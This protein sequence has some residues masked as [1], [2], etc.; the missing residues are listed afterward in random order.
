[1]NFTYFRR[2]HIRYRRMENSSDSLNS[3]IVI[4]RKRPTK[5]HECKIHIQ[6]DSK[7]NVSIFEGDSVSNCEKIVYVNMCLILNGC[8]DRYV[9]IS[10][11]NTIR[12][13]F[14]G[15]CGERSLQKKNGYTRRTARLHFV[16]YWRHKLTWKW[17]QTNKTRYSHTSCEV[18][19][20]WRRNFRTFTV[21]CKFVTCV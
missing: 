5:L 7:G 8:R 3:N 12:F 10:G 13:L 11:P 4:H 1:M 2:V 18:Y 21:N 9:W 15:L 14:V 20:G 19:W 16:C 6:G 17:T